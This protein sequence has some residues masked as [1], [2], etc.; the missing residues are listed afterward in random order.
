VPVHQTLYKMVLFSPVRQL[1]KVCGWTAGADVSPVVVT[2]APAGVTDKPAA[3]SRAAA[4]ASAA[5][6]PR[7]GRPRRRHPGGRGCS[8]VRNEMI[9][10]LVRMTPVAKCARNCDVLWCPLFGRVLTGPASRQCYLDLADDF[11]A[12][13]IS[14]C[15]GFTT[16]V[17]EVSYSHAQ[18]PPVAMVPSPHC[19]RYW[20][21]SPC[22]LSYPA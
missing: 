15:V 20:L 22:R 14:G 7:L 11:T 13:T 3:R 18:V 9:P 1:D 8:G 10:F 2:A 4:T 5:M 21:M 12:A 16:G 6:T 19:W 17:P